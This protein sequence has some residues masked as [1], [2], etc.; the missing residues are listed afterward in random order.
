MSAW[1][2]NK[3]QL[4]AMVIGTVIYTIID[5]LL[6]KLTASSSFWFTPI[7]FSSILSPANILFG[8]SL[9][10]PLFFGAEFGIWVGLISILVGSILGDAIAGIAS[11]TIWYIYLGLAI[12]GFFSGLTLLRPSSKKSIV[13]AVTLNAIGLIIGVIVQIIGFAWTNPATW[14]LTFLDSTV[15]YMLP[16]LLLL[17]IMLAIY[18]PIKQRKAQAA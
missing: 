6:D 13:R 8:L 14:I 5:Y 7:G 3:R 16:G 15:F 9:A 2:I 10:I 18:K 11:V 4:V 17:T 12:T 1:D